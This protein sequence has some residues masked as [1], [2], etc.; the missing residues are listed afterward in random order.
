MTPT[1]RPLPSRRF[2]ITRKIT[3]GQLDAL[4]TV[5]FYDDGKPGE[6]FINAGKAGSAADYAMRDALILASIALQYGVPAGYL[7][8][9]LSL[10]AVRAAQPGASEDDRSGSLVRAAVA[11][12]ASLGPFGAELPWAE[13]PDPAQFPG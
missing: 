4:C 7:E 11:W 9:S 12:A 6:I 8:K 2:G 5:N 1:R 10:D 13:A 3:V